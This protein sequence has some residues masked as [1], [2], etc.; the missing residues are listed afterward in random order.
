MAKMFGGTYTLDDLRALTPPTDAADKSEMSFSACL[1]A[2][3][4]LGDLLDEIDRLKR[5]QAEPK[6]EPEPDHFGLTSSELFSQLY[7][8]FSNALLLRGREVLEADGSSDSWQSNDWQEQLNHQ[9]KESVAKG[10]PVDIAMLCAFA[11]HHQWK[12]ELAEAESR[13]ALS[14]ITS[15]P[16]QTIGPDLAMQD[17]SSDYEKLERK[18]LA[19]TSNG[20]T[21]LSSL[22]IAY[23]AIGVECEP[24][25]PLDLDDLQRCLLLLDAVPELR[26]G[27]SAM[28]TVSP[29]WLCLTE[30]WAEVEA[31]AVAELGWDFGK[32]FTKPKD[33]ANLSCRAL[34]DCLAKG[35][36]V[37]AQLNEAAD[38]EHCQYNQTA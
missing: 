25:H 14:M 17:A 16:I 10:D 32:G 23:T 34:R 21:G 11:W 19:W 29:H 4:A 5:S 3:A 1:A 12:I 30:R 7:S 27:L 6:T 35:D 2:G 24:A 36:E 37:Q 20:D 28:A 13:S 33:A 26:K 22:C 8:D 18:V 38:Y 15:P 9:F 31:K